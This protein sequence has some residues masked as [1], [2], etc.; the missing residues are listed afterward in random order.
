MELIDDEENEQ[1]PIVRDPLQLEVLALRLNPRLSTLMAAEN[2]KRNL[3]NLSY[4]IRREPGRTDLYLSHFFGPVG[5]M[6][7]LE[8]LDEEP[9]TI[10]GEIFPEAAAR[11]RG[12]FQ[13]R[14]HQPRT[15]A[16]VYRWF[17]SKF[18]TARYDERDPG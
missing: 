11:N 2:I 17:D 3:Q 5:A 1:Q 9:T 16:E 4:K 15:V 6:V 13:N 7:F 14:Q 12:V 10:A 8:T 18:N